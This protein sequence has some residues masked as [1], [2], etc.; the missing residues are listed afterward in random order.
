[1]QFDVAFFRHPWYNVRI[2][3]TEAD[4]ES[5]FLCCMFL[6]LLLFWSEKVIAICAARKY[7]FSTY[8]YTPHELPVRRLFFRR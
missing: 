6:L 7:S 2:S 8:I 3:G 5:D 4:Y 1:M